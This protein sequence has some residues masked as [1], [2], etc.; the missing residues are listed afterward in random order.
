MQGRHRLV[1]GVAHQRL[2][3]VIK[4]L[5]CK[6]DVWI[7]NRWTLLGG[8]LSLKIHL[9]TAIKSNSS[10]CCHVQYRQSWCA[11]PPWLPQY[12]LIMGSCCQKVT[13]PTS[14]QVRSF[15]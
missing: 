8:P 6:A 2:E 12:F 3:G 5:H 15:E 10:P 7:S 13:N 1:R 11:T 9:I 4:V 14:G